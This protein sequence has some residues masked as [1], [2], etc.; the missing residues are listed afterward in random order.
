[1]VQVSGMVTLVR[2]VPLK[3]LPPIE[4]TL[5]GMVTLVIQEQLWNTPLSMAVTGHTSP[6]LSVAVAG[7]STWL[8]RPA[9]RES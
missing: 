6:S 1:M 9:A 3:A 5:S 4:R 7:T 8:G 2:P